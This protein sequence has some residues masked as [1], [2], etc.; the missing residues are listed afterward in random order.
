MSDVPGAPAPAPA[1]PAA[2]A[3]TNADIAAKVW[4]WVVGFF[5]PIAS[6][7]TVRTLWTVGLLVALGFAFGWRD[8]KLFGLSA[9]WSV[10]GVAIAY[11]AR[12]FL[13]PEVKGKEFYDLAKAGNVAAAIVTLRLALV[14]VACIFVVAFT[15]LSRGV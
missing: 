6:L 13:V 2:P 12:K 11:N 7:F 8:V 5:G 15:A 9:V 1:A 10:V 4:S 14:E 3:V